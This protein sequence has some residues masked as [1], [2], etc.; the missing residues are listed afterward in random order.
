MTE[1]SVTPR[2]RKR[3]QNSEKQNTL[4]GNR[5]RVGKKRDFESAMMRCYGR[6]D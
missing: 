2:K 1:S 5:K 6:M 4:V 3:G